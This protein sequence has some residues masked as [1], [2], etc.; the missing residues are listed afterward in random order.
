MGLKKLGEF[1]FIRRIRNGCVVRPAGVIQAI[2]DDAAAF[3]IPGNGAT[4]VTTDLMVEGVHL[5]KIVCALACVCVFAC[6][7][8]GGSWGDHQPAIS[9]NMLRVT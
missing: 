3:K 6:L 8:K 1:G 4:L 2:G 9:D 7:S 5:R